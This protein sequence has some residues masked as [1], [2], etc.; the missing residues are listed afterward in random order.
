MKTYIALLRGINVGGNTSFPMADLRVLCNEIGL[1]DVRTHIQS[2]NVVFRSDRSE[3]ELIEKLEQAIEMKKQKNIPVVLRTV[4]ELELVIKRNPFPDG[5][6]SQV[7]VMFFVDPLPKDFLEG[8]I[9][10]G[11]EEVVLRER[12]IFIHY[13][14]GMGR[15]KLKLP[16]SH[17]G[18]V[19]NMNTISKLYAL[20]LRELEIDETAN[21]K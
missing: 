3:K 2:G 7:G 21:R 18:T 17:L 20:S 1:E 14:N 10:T 15:S 9:S 11:P 6:P 4:E 13:P 5:I 16:L 8:V 19:R 12:E